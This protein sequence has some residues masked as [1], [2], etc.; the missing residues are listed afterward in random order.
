M[1]SKVKAGS[2]GMRKK[3][4]MEPKILFMMHLIFV[5]RGWGLADGPFSFDPLR[6]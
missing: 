3:I 2:K 5:A 1:R 6:R 4:P